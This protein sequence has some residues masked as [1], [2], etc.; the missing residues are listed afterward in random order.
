MMVNNGERCGGCGGGD[1]P[2]QLPTKFLRVLLLVLIFEMPCRFVAMTEKRAATRVQLRFRLIMEQKREARKQK[3]EEENQEL[4]Q[5]AM[6]LQKI[7][8]GNL[9]KKEH[10][11]IKEVGYYTG[12]CSPI[13]AVHKAG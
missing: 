6:K 7:Q 3:E 13:S 5:A 12:I 11:A 10:A 4:N 8:R 2:W 1:R 9:A